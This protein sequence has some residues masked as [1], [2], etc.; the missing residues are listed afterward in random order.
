MKFIQMI[1]NDILDFIATRMRSGVL[2]SAMPVVTS[3]GNSGMIWI[4][5]AILFMAIKKHRTDG[6]LLLSS[7]LLCALIGNLTIKP[8]VAR[9][10]PYDINMAI[11]LLIPKQ[12][13]FSFPSG[14]AMSSFAAA[15]VI[16]HTNRKIGVHAIILA[17]LIAFSRLYL[18]VHYPSDILVGI[19]IGILIG[20]ATI[21]LFR[22]VDGGL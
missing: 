22:L 8:L 4:C 1:D 9:I 2:D 20:I 7:L 19:I 13:G 17:S 5:A 10:R 15:T 12:T 6:L 11:T 21:Q 18:Y 14:H 3:L 16:F